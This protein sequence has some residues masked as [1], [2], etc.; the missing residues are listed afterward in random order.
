MIRTQEFLVLL[1]FFVIVITMMLL[2]NRRLIQIRSDIDGFTYTV[3]EVSSTR[4]ANMLAKLKQTME[5]FRDKLYNERNNHIEFKP[6]IEQL[7]ERFTIKTEISETPIG[8]GYTSY[9]VN[10][11]EKLSFCLRS[12]DTGD[13]HDMNLMMYVALH[14]LSHIACPEEDH[15]PLFWKIFGFFAQQA[16]NQGVYKKIDFNSEAEEY[17]GMRIASSVV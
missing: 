17:C 14:E 13:I 4:E 6:Y 1:M 3:G 2:S 16:V 5:Q 8:S 10:K 7:K 11:G 9:T 15:T 12:K